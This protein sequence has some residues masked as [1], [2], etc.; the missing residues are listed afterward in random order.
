MN[1]IREYGGPDQT[2]TRTEE[3]RAFIFEKI[4]E[5]SIESQ[6]SADKRDL[7]RTVQK[8]QGLVGVKTF[9]D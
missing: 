1:G 8:Q 5:F 4:L 6:M 7:K 2:R 3:L 9:V